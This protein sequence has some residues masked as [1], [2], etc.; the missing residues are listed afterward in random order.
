MALIHL[1]SKHGSPEF[2]YPRKLF[3]DGADFYRSSP[4][5]FCWSM[6]HFS[7]TPCK[8]P[9]LFC[10]WMGGIS[11]HFWVR[12]YRH[13]RDLLFLQIPGKSVL[14]RCTEMSLHFMLQCLF[15]PSLS[16]LKWLPDF[17]RSLTETT[18]CLAF[19]FGATPLLCLFLTPYYFFLK[20]PQTLPGAMVSSAWTVQR[21]A[22]L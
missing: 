13:S 4:T 7:A 20:A 12:G 18:Y 11:F 6:A 21:W 19:W 2:K 16:F 9:S 22:M 3:R 17:L 10:T 1:H 14:S 5:S 15:Q 8:N